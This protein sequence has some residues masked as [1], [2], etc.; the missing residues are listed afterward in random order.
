MKAA[1]L[2]G[3]GDMRYDDWPTPEVKPGTVK[4]AVKASGICGSD[5][6]RVLHGG[7]HWYPIVL[8]HEFAGVVCES[9]DGVTKVK[10]GDTVVVA[11]RIPCFACADCLAGNIAQCGHDSFIGSR[12]QGSFA[13]YIVVPEAN[14]VPYDP[15]VPFETAV[16]FEPATVAFHGVR[17]V[18]FDGGGDVAVVGAGTI[19]LFVL[20][21]AKA[22]GARNVVV[23][24]VDQARLDLA[25]SLGADAA[26]DSGRLDFVAEAAALTGSGGFDWVFDAAGNNA[27]LLASLRLAAA[28]ARIGLIGTPQQSVTFERGEWELI[29]RKEVWIRGCWQSYSLPFPGDEWRMTAD[30]F[31]D[32]SLK[33]DD[34]L[35]FRR[36][37]LSK[38]AEAFS[39]FKNPSQVHGKVLLIN[40]DK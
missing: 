34:R 19:G 36:Y 8:G 17:N 37:P 15:S 9:G 38:A 32:G 29:N 27:T 2:Y 33:A 10:P 14:V 20:Q 25:L 3:N 28:K 26:V 5:V 7:A 13:E 22:L 23:L 16:F 40:E 39:L 30:A 1:V 4:I 6:P 31:G 12:E 11:P 21:W 24:D 18:G 35:I